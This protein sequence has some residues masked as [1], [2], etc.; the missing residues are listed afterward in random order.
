MERLMLMLNIVFAVIGCMRKHQWLIHS[1]AIGSKANNRQC[2]YSLTRHVHYVLWPMTQNTLRIKLMYTQ[3]SS[4]IE[5][6]VLSLHFV[7]VKRV[8]SDY[9]LN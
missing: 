5:T 9:V 8:G 6:I 7:H 2:N 3:L 1:Y 4:V